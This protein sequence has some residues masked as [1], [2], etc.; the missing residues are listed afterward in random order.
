MNVG[1]K[2]VQNITN[3]LEKYSLRGQGDHAYM[4]FR[5]CLKLSHMVCLAPPIYYTFGH[6]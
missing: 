2:I 1:F 5:P 3:T 6:M 4:W